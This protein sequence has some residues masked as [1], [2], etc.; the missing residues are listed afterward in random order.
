VEEGKNI[1]DFMAQS[2]HP[3]EKGHQLIADGIMAYFK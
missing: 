1:N 3:N 2:N